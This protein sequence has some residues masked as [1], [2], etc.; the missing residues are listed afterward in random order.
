VGERGNGDTEHVWVAIC[1]DEGEHRWVRLVV[2]WEWLHPHAG[3]VGCRSGDGDDMAGDRDWNTILC[4]RHWK[5][6]LP[7]VGEC[8][9]G[10]GHSGHSVVVAE[11]IAER[12]HCDTCTEY[13]TLYYGREVVGWPSLQRSDIRRCSERMAEHIGCSPGSQ[14]G[15]AESQRSRQRPA[16]RE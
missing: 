2:D 10:D 8:E 1:G 5:V 16:N 15:R 6:L 4:L 3:N 12:T 9:I 14:S 7:F 13:N 11:R